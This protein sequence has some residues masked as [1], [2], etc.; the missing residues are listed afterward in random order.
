MTMKAITKKVDKLVGI[1]MTLGD[2]I[3]QIDGYDLYINSRDESWTFD[4]SGDIV[5]I[6]G[7]NKGL[8]LENIKIKLTNGPS[9]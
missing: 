2:L 7:P 6:T 9:E 3:K 1:E 4:A 5:E 8:T